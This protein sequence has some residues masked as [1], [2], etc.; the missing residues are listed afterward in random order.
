[1]PGARG[2][3]GNVKD[4]MAYTKHVKSIE[5]NEKGHIIYFAEL[6]AK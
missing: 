6:F 1:M 5:G 2:L 4:L 3:I